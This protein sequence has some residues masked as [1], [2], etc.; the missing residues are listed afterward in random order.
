MLGVLRVFHRSV[1]VA[2]VLATSLPVHAAG[3]PAWNWTGFYGGLNLGGISSSNK[4]TDPVNW[5]IDPSAPPGLFNPGLAG[6]SFSHGQAGSVFGVQFGYNW[7][8]AP[9]WL[10]GAEFDWQVSSA[11]ES[12]CTSACLPNPGFLS[13]LLTVDEQSVKWLATG[14]GRFG[15]ITPNGTLLYGTG[16]LAAGQIQQTVTGLASPGY[17][18]TGSDAAIGNFTHTKLGWTIGAGAE[19]PLGGR[20][21]AKLEYLFVDLGHVNDS[22]TTPVA[23]AVAG[24]YVL[25]Q[26]NTTEY[27]VHEHIVRIGL[28]YNFGG[29]GAA[30]AS[31]YAPPPT[32]TINWSGFYVGVNAGGALA[33]NSTYD[34]QRMLNY[35]FPIWSDDNYLATLPGAIAG[36]QIGYNWQIAPTWLAGVEADWQWSGQSNAVCIS[37]CFPTPQFFAPGAPG[38]LEGLTDYQAIRWLSTLRA[39][40]GWI[41]DNGTL[42]YGTAGVAFGRV[43]QTL[44]AFADA[45]GFFDSGTEAVAS[46]SHIR[47][48]WTIGG[49]IEMPVANHWSVKAEYLFVDLGTITNSY[50]TTLSPGAGVGTAL[51]TSSIVKVQDHIAR[52]GLNYQLN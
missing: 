25:S 14:R 15:W 46:F 47:T 35:A 50:T 5:N 37:E 19:L 23:V 12:I 45:P 9:S 42:V 7:Q 11:K 17:Y 30:G 43:D 38:Q 41:S 29:Q 27:N 40:G 6:D 32:A 44:D 21:S 10:A 34:P 4:T 22:F 28:N 18:A 31:P 1:V 3:P 8:I 36:A 24:P 26:T 13:Y 49:G 51:M 39:R 2:A 52:L 16:G 33:R 20:W 48:G